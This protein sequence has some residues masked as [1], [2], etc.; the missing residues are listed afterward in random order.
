M[1]GEN[2]DNTNADTV[3]VKITVGTQVFSATLENNAT[4]TAFKGRLPMTIN[5]QELN[6]NEKMFDLANNLPVNAYRPETIQTGDLMVYGA[7]TLVLFY[8]SFSTSYSYTRLGRVN[9]PS[10]LAT[11]LGTGN[12]TVTFEVE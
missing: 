9:D 11:A 12:I 8:K 2:N 6:G 7:R 3:K 4:A 5:M 10:G 1:K